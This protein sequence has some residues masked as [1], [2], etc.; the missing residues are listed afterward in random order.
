VLFAKIHFRI[1]SKEAL[2]DHDQELARRLMRRI[3]DCYARGALNQVLD[4][5]QQLE[6]LL[7]TLEHQL[8]ALDEDE[9]M[10]VDDGDPDAEVG[11]EE[12]FVA[13]W[14]AYSNGGPSF[15]GDR[16]PSEAHL[17]DVLQGACLRGM[18]PCGLRL[19][20]LPPLL[21][22]AAELARQRQTLIG[23]YR[24]HS[25]RFGR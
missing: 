11:V 24:A 12:Q 6:R 3:D 18:A 7:W 1:S 8:E 16:Q 9:E 25:R 22:I 19:G 5:E 21:P 10:Q 2:M 15:A 4:L 14:H 13:L 23:R 20:A 17:L